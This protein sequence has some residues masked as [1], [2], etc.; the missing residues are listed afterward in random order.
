MTQIITVC[1]VLCLFR[2]AFLF[3]NAKDSSPVGHSIFVPPTKSPQLTGS[4]LYVSVLSY[5]SKRLLLID[6]AVS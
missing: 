1:Y 2:S 4:V 6:V 5:K 3:V